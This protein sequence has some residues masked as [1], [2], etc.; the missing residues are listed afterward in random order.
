MEVYNTITSYDQ[1]IKD[2]L[3]LIQDNFDNK[4]IKDSAN[5]AINALFKEGFDVSEPVGARKITSAMLQKI[6]WRVMRKITPHKFELQGSQRPEWMETLMTFGLDTLAEKAEYKRLLTFKQGIYWNMFLYGDAYYLTG[7][8]E[9][10]N[11]PIV[12]GLVPNSNLYVDQF[13]TNMRATKGRNAI[14]VLVVFSM[15]TD[16]A[17]SMYPSLKRDQIKGCIPRDIGQLANIE[18]GRNN[19][20]TWKNMDS[21]VE[22][23]Y[24]FDIRDTLKPKFTIFAGANCKQVLKA[25]NDAYPFIKDNEPY[26]P[27]GNRM[28]MPSAEGFYNYGIGDLFYRLSIAARRLLNMAYGHAEDSVYPVTLVNVAQGESSKFFM[29]LQEAMKGRAIG[30]KPIVPIEYDPTNPRSSS[31]AAQSLITNAAIS[32]FQMMYDMIYRE[33]RQLGVTLDDLDVNPQA[34]QYQIAAEEEKQ[35]AWIK[36]V[37]EYNA[38]EAQNDLD[39]MLDFGK[40]FIKKSNRT[41]IDIPYSID[42]NGERVK[43]HSLTLGDWADELRKH[44][45]YARVDSSSGFIE[46]NVLKQVRI[47]RIM[48]YL[49]PGTKAFMENIREFAALNGRDINIDDMQPKQEQPKQESPGQEMP[50]GADLE[51]LLLPQPA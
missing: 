23:G 45:Y 29:S 20:Q 40:K 24:Y 22:V 30:K 48:P 7:T 47:Q 32:E 35:T 12:Y 1:S 21:I 15:A 46:S 5:T 10:E 2:A 3:R 37:Q 11:I 38:P 6:M 28:C 51:K 26:I 41:P 39:V 9:N 18:T 36:Q 4:R 42:I 43:P 44:H 17:Y 16:Q 34:T 31:V 14:Q 13:A 49:A 33:I 27:V 25:N 50:Q 19:Q 8:Q